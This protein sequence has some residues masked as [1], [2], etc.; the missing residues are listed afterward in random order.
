MRREADRGCR[1]RERAAR[2]H[3]LQQGVHELRALRR[4]GL[5]EELAHSRP[6]HGE[7]L[8][9]AQRVG[10]MGGR[11][12]VRD[13]LLDSS[14]QRRIDDPVT[15][16]R[17]PADVLD[18]GQHPC[19]SKSDGSS[20]LGQESWEPMPPGGPPSLEPT[21][22]MALS[23]RRLD[24]DH[25]AARDGFA[26]AHLSKDDG[27][28][29]IE[30]ERPSRSDSHERVPAR[31]DL[32]G[33]DRTQGRVRLGGTDVDLVRAA[34]RQRMPERSDRSYP[35]LERS[36]GP[37][38]VVSRDDIAAGD[39]PSFHPHDVHR[40]P[41]DGAR[42]IGEPF[43]GLEPSDP[44]PGS[45]REDGDL[46]PGREAAVDERAGDD[47]AGP[48]DGEHAIHEQPG[49]VPTVGGRTAGRQPLERGAQLVEPRARV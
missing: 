26:S 13:P 3:R 46:V 20:L 49:P 33:S 21:G 25:P 31:M 19:V 42:A 16:V 28:E 38:V 22:I 48:L 40:H 17:R 23:S 47:G 12:E 32:R 2:H 27:I 1:A 44:R 39:L 41:R 34:G 30:H 7:R 9:L 14:E 24:V 43:V 45:S 8:S 4:A 36:R 15:D 5:R 10:G 18:A 35:R 11:E 29:H 37:P 6:R